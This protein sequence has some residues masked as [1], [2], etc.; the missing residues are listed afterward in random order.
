MDVLSFRCLRPWGIKWAEVLFSSFASAEQRR[1][2]ILLQLVFTFEGVGVVIRSSA[3]CYDQGKIK[4]T[5]SEGKYRYSSRRS[6]LRFNENY[7]VG[8]G[9][10]RLQQKGLGTGNVIGKSFRFCL[11]LRLSSFLSIWSVVVII[12]IGEKW[13]LS[14]SSN[15]DFVEL[16]TPLRVRFSVFTWSLV[17]F[18]L[19]LRLRLQFRR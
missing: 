19:Q 5:K 10:G 17:S 2:A 18:L 12:G 16:M 14:D 8:V 3:G 6:R 9:S 11:R 4:P 7:R 13:N 15:S 1:V